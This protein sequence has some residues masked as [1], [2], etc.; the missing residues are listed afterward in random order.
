MPDIEVGLEIQHD[1]KTRV[2]LSLPAAGLINV[3]VIDTHHG[4]ITAHHVTA[5]GIRNAL[6][7][8][9]LRAPGAECWG[10]GTSVAKCK[11]HPRPCCPDCK[12]NF[13]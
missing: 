10:C 7:V 9:A 4:G 5:L 13:A 2:L 3:P 6:D 12:C 11:A 1:G 8:A